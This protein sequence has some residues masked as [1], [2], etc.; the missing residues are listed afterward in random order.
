MLGYTLRRCGLSLAIVGLV[1]LGLFALLHLMPGDP[2]AIALGP[3][4]TPEVRARYAAKMHLDQ[5]VLVQLGVFAGNMLRGDLGEDLFSG[6]PVTGIVMADL[7]RTLILAAAGLG[8]SAVLG[9]ALGCLSAVRPNGWFDRITGVIAVGTIAI[10]SFLVSIWALLIFAIWLGWLPV[11]GAG[12]PCNLWDQAHHLILPAFAVG[13]GWVGY[14]ARMVRA[15]MLEVLGENYIR[16]ARAAG[17]TERKVVWNY[18]LRMAILPTVTMLGIG[19]GSL[20]TGAV[21]AEIIFA[22]PG[23]GKL[24]Y[25]MVETRNFPVVQGAVLVMTAVYVAVA[26]LADLAVAWLDPRVRHAL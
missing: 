16:A 15:S 4:A 24:V 12:E 7:G 6:R 21:F 10:P 18:A 9:I 2:A 11:I 19:F 3:R 14:L 25:D 20:L 23:L 8:W 17:L 26:L 1:M 13:L 5:P 22:R